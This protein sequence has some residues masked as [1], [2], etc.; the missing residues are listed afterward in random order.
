MKVVCVYCEAEGS[1][2]VI[3]QSDPIDDPTIT[4]GLCAKHRQRIRQEIEMLRQEIGTRPTRRFGRVPV[5]IPAVAPLPQI[6]GGVLLGTV[7]A[8]GDGGML[9][10][11]PIEI[12]Q[13][14]LLQVAL[15]HPPAPLEFEARVVWT[16]KSDTAVR[17]G[18]AFTVPKPRGFAATLS[19]AKD[20]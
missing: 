8:I 11:F 2:A 12:A 16:A 4:H 14:T 10:E 17:H 15:Q 18:L 13:G 7:R 3:G 19:L 1:P 5:A 20:E 9:V 6:G